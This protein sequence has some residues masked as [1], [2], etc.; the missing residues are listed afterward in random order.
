MT[1][2]RKIS[3]SADYGYAFDLRKKQSKVTGETGTLSVALANNLA[4]RKDGTLFIQ[5]NDEKILELQAIDERRLI[6]RDGKTTYLTKQQQR[7]TYALSMFLSQSK[8]EPEIKSYVQKLAQGETPKSRIT[9]PISITQLTKLVTT[10]NKARARQKKDVLS[11]LQAMSEIKQVQTFGEYGTKEGQVRL[12]AP[13][14]QL[15]EQVED[16]SKDKELDADFIAVTFGSIFFYELYNKY[17]IV[18][19]SLFSIWGKAGSGTDTELF[20]TLLSDLLAKYSQHRIASIKAVEKIRRNQYKKI[21]DY[22]KAKAKA[23]KDALTYSEYTSTIKERVTTDYESQRVYRLNFKRD[24]EKAI[25][26]LQD[27]GLLTEATR[28]T[29]TKK[30]DRVDFVFSFDYNKQEDE[31]VLTL[32]GVELEAQEIEDVEKKEAIFSEDDSPEA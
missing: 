16:L 25:K 30:G 19:P 26:A 28:I 23:Q 13:L 24:L 18:K 12:I 21:E 17:A 9:L 2:V 4:S 29:R 10:D 8:E 5:T 7:L 20:A 31:L 15:S 32:P 6:D 27:Y 11:N 1:D 3:G 22:Y 14:I